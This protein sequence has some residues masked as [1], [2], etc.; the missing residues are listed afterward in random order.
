MQRV[1]FVM[2]VKDG[3]Q[4]EYIRRHQQ[5]WPEVLSGLQRAGVHKMSVFIKGVELF[6]YME[7]EDY[8]MAIRILGE[9]PDMVRWE[10][11]MAPIME[12]ASGESYDPAS[13]YPDGLHE[14]FFW[15]QDERGP[16]ERYVR[17]E[18]CDGTTS[19]IP[20]SPPHFRSSKQVP[21]QP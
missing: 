5:V 12:G 17:S 9:S 3:E 8:A 18:T 19:V 10:D 13:P 16:G 14:V 7:V 21:F 15:D 1:A 6:L 11:Y 2:R 20:P 4:G